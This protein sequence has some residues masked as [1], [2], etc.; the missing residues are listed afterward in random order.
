MLNTSEAPVS[1][2]AQILASFKENNIPL[3]ARDIAQQLKTPVQG[4]YTNIANLRT[5]G[6]IKIVDKVDGLTRY[7]FVKDVFNDKTPTVGKVKTLRAKRRA[8]KAKVKAPPNEGIQIP[9]NEVP[10]ETSPRTLLAIRSLEDIERGAQ[11]LRLILE[12]LI[13]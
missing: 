5:K 11:T 1:V 8:R 6:A 4:L 7:I 9:T 12:G 10:D 13:K 3:N 2:A